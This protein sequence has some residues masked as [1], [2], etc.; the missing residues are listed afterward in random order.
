M[1]KIWTWVVIIVGI[2]IGL[3]TILYCG[4]KL[5]APSCLPPYEQ[6]GWTTELQRESIQTGNVIVAALKKYHADHGKYPD[7][8]TDLVPQY[9]SSIPSPT[10]GD[11]TWRYRSSGGKFFLSFAMPSGYPSGNYS[12]ALDDWFEDS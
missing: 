7:V 4:V 2:N 6:R 11:R 12:L 3:L 8:L 10:A 9:L 1:A 5:I